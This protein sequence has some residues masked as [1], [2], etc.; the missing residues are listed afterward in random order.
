MAQ[1]II[2][3]LFVGLLLLALDP[4]YSRSH[5]H[6]GNHRS[7]R[8]WFGGRGPRS[9]GPH[10]PVAGAAAFSIKGTAIALFPLL[11]LGAALLFLQLARLSDKDT[12]AH[13]Q[14]SVKSG[15]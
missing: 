11:I 15:P 12:H 13:I 7:N 3:A 8:Y 5:H 2:I 4:N 10:Y 14:T 1:G 9:S 6:R